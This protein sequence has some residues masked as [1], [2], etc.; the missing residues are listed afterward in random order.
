MNPEKH[1]LLLVQYYEAV[2][3][4]DAAQDALRQAEY[5]LREIQMAL[6]PFKVGDVVEAKLYVRGEL[7][8]WD[9]AIVR[10]VDF[11][12]DSPTPHAYKIAFSNKDGSWSKVARWAF[13][14]EVRASEGAQE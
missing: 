11:W 1:N 3:R 8:A 5:R 10:D 14:T 12:W 9:R 2:A 6:A 7:Y 13:H 4:V